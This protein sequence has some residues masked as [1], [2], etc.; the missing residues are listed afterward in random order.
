MFSGTA[1]E[2]MLPLYTVYKA[3]HLWDK[4]IIGGPPNAR[5]ICS[6]SGWFNQVCFNDWFTSI[7]IPYCRKIE[8]V[9]VLIG[10]NLSSHLNETIIEHLN[11]RFV[12]LPSNSA[13][14][15]QP[16]DVVTL[17]H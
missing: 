17:H 7:V 5:Y 8:A 15:T 1:S 11:I 10:D 3:E 6:K 2:E 16:L 4:W 13:H 9:E 14:L 12:V